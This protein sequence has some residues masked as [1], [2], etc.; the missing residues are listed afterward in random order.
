MTQKYELIHSVWKRH[1][2]HNCEQC[3]GFCG[4]YGVLSVGKC[5]CKESDH[6]GHVLV[7]S[8]IACDK[9]VEK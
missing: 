2:Y 1:A 7:K 4:V 3:K 9:L 6:Y 8:H 5:A